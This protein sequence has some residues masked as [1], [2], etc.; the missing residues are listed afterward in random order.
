MIQIFLNIQFTGKTTVYEPKQSHLHSW[1]TGKTWHSGDS[2]WTLQLK[3]ILLNIQ[4]NM[5]CFCFCFI[6]VHF[7]LGS[8]SQSLRYLTK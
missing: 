6:S 8:S 3:D 2:H 5:F 7:V 1:V 4:N